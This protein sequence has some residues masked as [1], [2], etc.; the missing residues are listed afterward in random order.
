MTSEHSTQNKACWLTC[1]FL[2]NSRT[3]KWCLRICEFMSRVKRALPARYKLVLAGFFWLVSITATLA[4]WIWGFLLSQQAL[5][6]AK[7]IAPCS[8]QPWVSVLA[9]PL[10]PTD[11]ERPPT[12]TSWALAGLVI[13]MAILAFS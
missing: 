2:P 8:S 3:G 12:D 9:P 10:K 1:I 7:H 4:Y 11:G 6:T 13:L 5:C